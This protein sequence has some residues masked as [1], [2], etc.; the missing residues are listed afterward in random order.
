VLDVRQTSKAAA[1]CTNHSRNIR[2]ISHD[3]FVNLVEAGE[4]AGALETLL[5]KNRHLTKRNR[6][7]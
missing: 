2:F 5:D 1:L 6:K 3:L 4:Q 7:R